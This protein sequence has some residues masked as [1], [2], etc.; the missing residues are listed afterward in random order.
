MS[1]A[2]P[3]HCF[4]L[5]LL[6]L[7]SSGPWLPFAGRKCPN[8]GP[9]G[10][11]SSDPRTPPPPRAT[12]PIFGASLVPRPQ[13]SQSHEASCWQ[14]QPHGQP[15]RTW[16]QGG[17]QDGRRG[18][19]A[20]KGPESFGGSARTEWNRSERTKTDGGHRGP[21]ASHLCGTAADSEN[22]PKGKPLPFMC[23]PRGYHPKVFLDGQLPGF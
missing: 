12:R 5:H 3:G 1:G 7:L 16:R 19:G 17:E 23:L 6:D 2:G 20:P 4:F 9:S 18:R 21:K 13:P 11:R 15:S 10:P 22:G 14:V 8:P